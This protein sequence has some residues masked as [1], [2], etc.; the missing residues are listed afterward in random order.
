MA[1]IEEREWPV[2]ITVH[3]GAGTEVVHEVT[4][5]DSP[6]ARAAF[7]SSRPDV[8]RVDLAVS[9]VNGVPQLPPGKDGQS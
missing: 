3:K 5:G 9:F 8:V 4:L 2:R 7:W 1:S 6:M